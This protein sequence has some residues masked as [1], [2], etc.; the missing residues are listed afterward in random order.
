[1]ELFLIEYKVYVDF[2]DFYLDIENRDNI[3]ESKLNLKNV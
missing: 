1:M 2:M 3:K